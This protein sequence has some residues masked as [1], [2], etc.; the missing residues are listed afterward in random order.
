MIF[1][2]NNKDRI[3]I[4]KNRKSIR[5]IRNGYFR[6][7]KKIEE[8]KGDADDISRIMTGISS[9]SQWYKDN[10]KYHESQILIRT[11]KHLS[12]PLPNFSGLGDDEFWESIGDIGGTIK[13]EAKYILRKKIR[14]E[15]KEIR[16]AWI[17][18]VSIIIGLIGALTALISIIKD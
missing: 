8:R 18:H 9:E 17:S 14:A 15:K 2:E 10:I 1:I 13:D 6:D 7:I 5:S 16:E 12:L 4:Y 3:E 11:A